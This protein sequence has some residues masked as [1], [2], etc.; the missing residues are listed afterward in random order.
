MNDANT[1]MVTCGHWDLLRMLPSQLKSAKLAAAAPVWKRWCNIKKAMTAHSG[2]DVLGMPDLLETLGLPLVGRH[3]SGIDDA[4]NIAACARE[5]LK[6]DF[7]FD[8]TPVDNQAPKPKEP[9]TLKPVGQEDLPQQKKKQT[10]KLTQQQQQQ[11]Q[12]RKNQPRAPPPPPPAIGP[13]IDIGA[14]LAHTPFTRETLPAVLRAARAA[15]VHHIMITGTSVNGSRDAIALCREFNAHSD[16][17]AGAFPKLWCTVGVHPHDSGRAVAEAKGD[18][19]QLVEMLEGMIRDNSDVVV[20]VGECG[21]DF[22]RNFS[23]PENQEAVFVAQARLSVRLKMPLFLHERSAHANFMNILETVNSEGCGSVTGCLHCY[24]GDT[25]QHLQSCLDA[26]LYVGITGWVT[27]EREGRGAALAAIS[28]Q[29]PL[30]RLMVETDA[31]FLLPRN[32]KPAPKNCEPALVGHVAVRLAE[33]RGIDATDV[34]A[35][36]TRNAKLLFNLH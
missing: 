20:A 12:K 33:L 17:A 26:G 10:P 5:L 24:T 23:T 30:N 29:I 18:V 28:T 21:L 8:A 3:H 13:L 11:L 1:L 7:V 15:D 2:V 34:A 22:D 16:V 4:R 19:S 25:V 32:I 35:A 31:P 27:D 6:R 14:N 36:S 9:K